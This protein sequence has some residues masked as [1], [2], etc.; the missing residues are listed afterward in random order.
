MEAN[1]EIL[2]L[3]QKD[4]RKESENKDI[5]DL[6]YYDFKSA[7]PPNSGMKAFN[8]ASYVIFKSIKGEIKILKNKYPI[9]MNSSKIY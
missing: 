1:N 2:I 9:Y 6:T 7:T 3:N 4:L 8:E 5:S